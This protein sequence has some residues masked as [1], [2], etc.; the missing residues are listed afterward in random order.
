MPTAPS[1][2]PSKKA[3]FTPEFRQGDAFQLIE[4]L[5]DSS[6]DLII[7]SPPYW[8][9][10]TY[11]LDHNWNILTEW[12]EENHRWSPPS[13]DWYRDHG[14]ILGLEPLPDWYVK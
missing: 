13:W 10:R 14:G 7:T 4:D 6:I 11:G 3:V 1:G 9:H 8:G 2:D 5:D 12:E